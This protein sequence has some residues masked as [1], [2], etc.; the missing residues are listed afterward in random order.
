MSRFPIR[1]ILVA[2]DLGEGSDELVRSSAALAAVSGAE[3][4]VLHVIDLDS[5]PYGLREDG[6]IPSLPGRIEEAEGALAEQ[7]RR[8]VPVGVPV[9]P[10]VLSNATHQA[11]TE[12]AADVG[13][14]L[15]VLGPHRGGGP[16]GEFL[17]STADRVIRTAEVPCLILRGPLSLPLRRVGV[18]V[19]F[20][21]PARGALQVALEWS[22]W[23]EGTPAAD[24]ASGL[25]LSVFYVASTI[26]AA[27]PDAPSSEALLQRLGREVEA[28]APTDGSPRAK[29]RLDIR[30]ETSPAA[31]ILSQAREHGFDLLV[32]GT[33]GYGNLTRL[34]IGSVASGVARRA[35]C[36]VLLVPPSVVRRAAPARLTERP[37]ARLHRVLLAVDFSEASVAAA[38]WTVRHFIPDAEHLFVHVLDVKEPP[39]FLGGPTAATAQAIREAEKAADARLREITRDLNAPERIIVRQGQPVGEVS[40]LATEERVDLIAVGP[41][42]RKGLA[43]WLGSSAESLLGSSPVPVL[44]GRRLPPG[45]PTRILAAVD[46]SERA[47]ELL[48]WARALRE[49][50]GAALEVI[51][52]VNVL[53]FEPAFEP[54]GHPRLVTEATKKAEAS[55]LRWLRERTVEAG[56]A[57]EEVR[58]RVASGEPGSLILEVAER[59]GAELIVMGSRGAGTAGRL[60][61]G[62]VARTVLRD[63]PCPVFVV[64]DPARTRGRG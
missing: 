21:E 34:L 25:E 33:H 29:V 20:S 10:R 32:M 54:V 26:E 63:A 41:H 12:H 51:F 1:S 56:L 61:L 2:T 62:S 64:G 47:G 59:S 46:E 9:R 4:S 40:R 37:E 44:L 16:A 53:H 52:A 36:P 3:L 19:D 38:D 23:L 43:G 28:A 57:E 15:I 31:G 14:D 8:V 7:V 35:P 6:R 60:L 13:A 45:P 50:F 30:R 18:P 5:P 39:A 42:A 55:A 11:I 49:R 22:A 48:A 17:G 24:E 27:E 58:L